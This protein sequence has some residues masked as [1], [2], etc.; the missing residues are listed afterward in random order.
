MIVRCRTWRASQTQRH[1]RS[2]VIVESSVARRS[3]GIADYGPG[4][5]TAIGAH[6]AVAAADSVVDHGC[7]VADPITGRRRIW[8]GHR[9]AS[10]RPSLPG[11]LLVAAALACSAPGTMSLI[12][13]HSQK[14]VSTSS[15]AGETAAGPVQPR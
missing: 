2:A 1:R 7:L 6:T 10:A 13:Q 8:I 5:R 3:R 9:H 4:G 11:V 12:R 15:A 14:V